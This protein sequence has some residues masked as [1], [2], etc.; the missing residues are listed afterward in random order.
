MKAVVRRFLLLFLLA[1]WICSAVYAQQTMRFRGSDGW[2][3][4]SQYERLFDNFN[5][6]TMTATVVRVDTATPARRTMDM[7]VAL[8]LIVTLDAGG[9]E[10]PVHLGP[11]WFAVHQDVS[12]PR[13]EKVEIRGHRATL[14]GS[15]F[16]MPVEIRAT[17]HR[18]AV[19]RFR[20][21]DGNAFWYI[22]RPPN[23]R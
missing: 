23:R 7:G 10:I 15:D 22:H 19:F 3:H 5:L 13:G 14:E 4:D 17:R 2:G 12:F 21:D 6:R 16:I 20:D 9:E 8:R 11:F 1:A 18:D